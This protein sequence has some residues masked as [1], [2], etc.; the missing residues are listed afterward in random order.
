VVFYG[1]KLPY[2]QNVTLIKDVVKITHAAGV[3]VEGELGRIGGKEDEVTVNQREAVFTVPE[4][5]KGFVEVNS[6][7]HI[8]P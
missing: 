3:I 7:R 5:A 1:S 4:K 6:G 2:D 8:D